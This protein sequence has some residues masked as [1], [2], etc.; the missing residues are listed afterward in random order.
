MD[1]LVLLKRDDRDKYLIDFMKHHQPREGKLT[2]L[3]VVNTS[4][5]IPL[6]TNGEV[7]DNCTE[8]DLS[9]YYQKVKDNQLF[10]KSQFPDIDVISRIGNF[11]SILIHELAQKE[12]HLLV[13][14]AHLSDEFEDVFQTNLNSHIINKVQLPYLTLKCDNSHNKLER[15]LF[16]GEFNTP[17]AR[18]NYLLEHLKDLENSQ[19]L[20]ANTDK[21][22]MHNW[23]FYQ[24][25]ETHFH[26]I[27][28]EGSDLEES[29]MKINP[30]LIVL[31][32]MPDDQSFWNKKHNKISLVNHLAKPILII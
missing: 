13:S 28:L 11:E 30:D 1:T 22:S 14:G 21:N 4:G 20:Y 32:Q 10:F 18:A 26:E 2:F 6:K 19:L 5:E 8:F 27:N 15:V 12:Y 16:I 7:L 17:S 25:H 23:P 9:M 31:G 29:I 24:S 3:N